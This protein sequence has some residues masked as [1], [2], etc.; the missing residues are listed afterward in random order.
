MCIRDRFIKM[1]AAGSNVHPEVFKNTDLLKILP[2][3]MVKELKKST[4]IDFEKDKYSEIRDVVTTI[5]HNH[6]NASAPMYMDKKTVLSIENK[7]EGPKRD[8]AQQQ[9]EEAGA[10]EGLPV[11]NEKGGIACY[12]GKGG[13]GSWQVKGKGGKG[14]GKDGGYKFQGQCWRCGKNR[15]QEQ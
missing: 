14:K 4:S 11:Y 12:I 1:K 8:E 7:E 10:E 15:P 9:E 13:G 2:D 3:M 5:V 6:M